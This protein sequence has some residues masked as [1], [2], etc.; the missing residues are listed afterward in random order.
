MFE[1]Q[2]EKT[3]IKVWA[4][5]LE[6]G[7]L[8]QAQHIANL[9]Y[10]FRH[11]ALM[12]DVHEGFG[13]PIGGVLATR[14]V[15]IPN[16]V[17]VDIGC[18]MNAV[19]T[20]LDTVGRKDLESIIGAI[21]SLIPVG[22]KHHE[23]PQDWEGFRNA[24]D[25]EIVRK[26][27]SDAR[28]QL[29]SLGGGN[30]FIEVQK[31]SD[32]R[33]WLMLHSGSRHFGYAVAKEFYRIAKEAAERDKLKL[34]DIQLAPLFWGSQ[35]AEQYLA[36]MHFAQ[37]FA[38]AS[39]A[40]MM[41]RVQEVLADFF[42]TIEYGEAVNIH[43]NFASVET[44][45][46][47]DVVVHRKGAT[48]ARRGEKGIIPGSQGS[49]SYIVEG[50]GNPESFRSCSHGAGR[51]MGRK[52]A[53]RKLNLKQEQKIMDRQGIV[54]GL[55]SNRDLDEAAGA[56]KKIEDVM[57]QQKDLVKVLVELRPLAVIKG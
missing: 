35:E 36:A 15:V 46:G 45:Y 13:M 38:A 22:F 26:E 25:V 18:G 9:P 33:I 51:V 19:Q 52:E 12:P 34:P 48:S 7:A 42:P 14:D 24:P 50:L 2:S 20:S 6:G 57:K 41:R 28:Y 44:H 17:G 54:H 27:L 8:L 43:H 21:R 1:I 3:P 49:K 29:G 5:S 37:D 23:R 53:R 10:T 47:T 55:H 11:V 56:Y 16:A 40:Q 4:G 31:G 30:H 32:G 39:R